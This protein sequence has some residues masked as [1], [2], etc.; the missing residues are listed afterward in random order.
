M[1]NTGR[2]AFPTTGVRAALFAFAEKTCGGKGG[3][4]NN[5]GVSKEQIERAKAVSILDYLL[6]HECH[7]FKRVGNAYY[8]RDPEHNSLEVSNNLWNWHSHGI[9]GNHI[10]NLVTINGY[11]FVDQGDRV[12]IYEMKAV[13]GIGGDPQRD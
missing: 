9:G 4:T 7:N 10:D 3:P 1:T 2:L 13:A 8:R 12:K 11:S 5:G 6:S